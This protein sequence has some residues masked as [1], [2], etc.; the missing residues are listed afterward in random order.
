MALSDGKASPHYMLISNRNSFLNVSS[1]KDMQLRT[2]KLNF[3]CQTEQGR[4]RC[5]VEWCPV[6][7]SSQV[8]LW[9]GE[10]WPEMKTSD[11]YAEDSRDTYCMQEQAKVT[12]GYGCTTNQWGKGIC[13]KRG[14]PVA[15][16]RQSKHCKKEIIRITTL[17]WITCQ[18]G[19]GACTN[20]YKHTSKKCTASGPCGQIW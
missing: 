15:A 14:R 19:I 11:I 10:Q 7:L 3:L 8:L 12:R 20:T 4:S 6:A 2:A 18:Y 16:K 5:L 1:V 13:E 9:T 17:S